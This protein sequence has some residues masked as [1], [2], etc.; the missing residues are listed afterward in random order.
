M[1]PPGLEPARKKSNG[2]WK[3]RIITRRISGISPFCSSGQNPSLAQNRSNSPLKTVTVTVDFTR[4]PAH[5]L[6]KG[7][8]GELFPE[9]EII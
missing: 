3:D 6:A 1:G 2:M 4:D 7:E 5:A 8:V 9:S